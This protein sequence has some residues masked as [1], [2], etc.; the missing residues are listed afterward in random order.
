MPGLQRI[1]LLLVRILL[2][3]RDLEVLL[4]GALDSTVM[5]TSGPCA[6]MALSSSSVGRDQDLT[7]VNNQYQ[8]SARGILQIRKG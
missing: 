4:P 8:F 7:L 5:Q 1:A 6:N 3:G 2:D